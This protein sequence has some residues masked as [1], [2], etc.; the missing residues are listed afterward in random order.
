MNPTDLT[1]ELLKEITDGF[2]EQRKL[3]RGAYGTV[4]KGERK[5][6]D[7]IAVKILHSNALGFDDKQFENEFE[8][9]RRVK[10][11]NIVRLVGYCYELHH[12]YED[13][14][15]RPIFVA[16]I[17]R[18]LCFEYMP[19][20]SLE[21]HL[22][23]E[24]HGLDWP[25]RYKIIKGT[26]EGLKYLHEEQKP[27]IYH[28]DLKPGNILLDKDMVPKLADFGLSKIFNEEKTKIIQ[29]PVGTFGYLPPEYLQK[30]VVSNKLDIFS[31]GVVMIKIIAGPRGHSR[32]FEMSSKEFTESVLGN[33]TSR[34]QK[35]LNGSSLEACC[36]Q[37][38]ACTEIALKCLE[39]EREKRP[40][41]VDIINQ[42]PASHGLEKLPSHSDEFVTLE[43]KLA[44][45]NLGNSQENQESDHHKS[46][47]SK[48][49]E[50]DSEEDQIIPME[51]P[52]VPIDVHP[53]EPWILTS[54]MFG[55]VDILNYNTQETVNLIQGS[56]GPIVTAA[57][58]IARKQWF[59]VGHH[60][61]FIRVYTYESPVKQ[62]K[63]FKAHNTWTI[64]CLDVHPTEPY[65]LSMGSQDRIKLWDW[66]KGWGCIKTFDIHG[67]GYQIKFNPKDTHKFAV[68]SFMD[69]QVW[70][71]RSSRHEFTLSGY[72]SIVTSFD[73][74]T[75]GNQLYMI[76]GSWDNTAKIWDCQRRTCVQTLEG[77]MD[78]VS[79][80]CSHPDLPVL[81]TG[82]NDETVR[83]WNSTTFKLESVLDFE[84]GKVTAIACLK[85]SKRVVI[86][87]D[88]GLVITEIRPKQLPAGPSNT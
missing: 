21:N 24:L 16:T 6:G 85:G 1:F 61:G 43:S 55:S 4:Y 70:N 57:K 40:N 51:Y 71:I 84:L 69:V 66:D 46:S 47:C 10:H 23:D 86:G 63:R 68:T 7:E 67:I 14:N 13:D 54:N 3:G 88:S 37:V 62:V 45:Q 36:Q 78:C 41:I 56:Y 27:P 19:G 60:D 18:A 25:I 34:L 11:P 72:G 75:R 22:S 29:T 87:H 32:C 38:K 53:S 80:V 50:E 59:V 12:T 17:H 76:T 42:L 33:W 8:N 65:V 58:F 44:S 20:G 30:N 79:C 52:D 83:V 31:L 9:L 82:S 15:G 64:T 39:T 26:C 2:S 28:L 49:K 74:F 81:L 77:H 48:E 73:Y 5:N 35:T